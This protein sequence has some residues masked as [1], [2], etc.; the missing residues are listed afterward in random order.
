M[1]S[2]SDDDM[3][4]ARV[5][6][7]KKRKALSDEDEDE[8]DDGKGSD[9]RENEE[10]GDGDDDEEEGEEESEYEGDEDGEE[11]MRDLQQTRGLVDEPSGSDDS[12]DDD[13]PLSHLATKKKAPAKKKTPA[14]KKKVTPKKKPVPRKKPDGTASS[15]ATGRSTYVSPSTELYAKS[16]KGKLIQALL[17]RWWYAIEWPDKSSV[18]KIPPANTDSLEGFPG[19]YVYTSGESVGKLYDM[20]DKNCPNC[21]NFANMV[22]KPASELQELL[23]KA[24]EEQ[25]SALVK[26][27]GEGTGTEKDLNALLK[28]AKKLSTTKADRDAEKVLKAARLKLPSRVQ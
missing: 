7:A 8:S 2:D 24:I 5:A 13:V 4:I 20:R 6:A 25:K 12:S 19:V 16:E 27:H 22:H 1:S 21:P 26:H 18:L 10:D 3:P 23:L 9:D 14:A 17:S 11:E 28:W 15:G